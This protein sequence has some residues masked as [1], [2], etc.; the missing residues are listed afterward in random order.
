MGHP[1]Y[2]GE[3]IFNPIRPGLFSRPADPWGH[4]GLDAKSQNY[5]Q[6]IEIKFCMGHC[7]YKS[8]PDAKF[9]SG[10]FSSFGYMTSQNFPL[11]KVTSHRFRIFIPG[12]WF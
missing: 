5:H 4:R 10:S 3:H 8:M 12:K 2:F 11:K 6:L 9:E 1:V 7:S